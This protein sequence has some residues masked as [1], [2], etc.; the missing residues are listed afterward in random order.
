MPA[1]LTK[2]RDFR[3]MRSNHPDYPDSDNVY[4]LRNAAARHESDLFT[5]HD[6]SLF[7]PIICI[8]T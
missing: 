6:S 8:P 7:P 3:Y 2:P 1:N 4:L 5:E